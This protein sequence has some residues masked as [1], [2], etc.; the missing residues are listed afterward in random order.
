MVQ[1]FTNRQEIAGLPALSVI[2]FL[3]NDD[4]DV[5]LLSI[6]GWFRL[7]DDEARDVARRFEEDGLIESSS[8][9]SA[10]WVK[11]ISA[12]AIAEGQPQ[13]QLADV[14]RDQIILALVRG[15]AELNVNPAT[16]HRVDALTLLGA[17][18]AGV[19]EPSLVEALV[20]ISPVTK[21]GEVQAGIEGL[22]AEYAD[23]HTKNSA[24]GGDARARSV[25]LIKEKLWSIDERLALR[26]VMR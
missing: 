18:I 21:V 1:L 16:A 24:P 7:D 10:E 25:G 3:A 4:A 15:I 22:A 8:D 2:A 9:G 23:Q 26:F 20:E 12:R 11:S 17:T 6:Q 19:D 14:E 13:F 5:S